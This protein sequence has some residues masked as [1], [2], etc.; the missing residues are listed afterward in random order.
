MVFTWVKST[1]VTV[2]FPFI[3]NTQNK[4]Y[5]SEASA[6]FLISVVSPEW[7]SFRNL[8]FIL[9]SLFVTIEKVFVNLFDITQFL[10][11]FLCWKYFLQILCAYTASQS[12]TQSF[13]FYWICRIFLALLS[14]SSLSS[15]SS[16]SS[17]SSLCL[18]DVTVIERLLGWWR[19]CSW[20]TAWVMIM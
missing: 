4:H 11:T 5:V 18:D 6:F 15:S 3:T 14:S 17:S 12:Y 2:T 13:L 19:H 8:L 1:T 16:S 20:D 7:G 9:N 10:F